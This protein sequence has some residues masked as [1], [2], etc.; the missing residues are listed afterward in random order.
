MIK[1]KIQNTSNS[2]LKSI[3]SCMEILERTLTLCHQKGATD[4][5]VDFQQ[6]HGFGVDVRM[7][8]LESI[9]FH[10]KQGL[11]VVVYRGQ[12]KGAA[13]TTDLR[14][15][16]I[17]WAVQAACD[18]ASVSAEDP[19]YGL[20]DGSIWSTLM[21]NDLDLYHPWDIN[22]DQAIEKAL[23]LETHARQQ[24]ARIVNSDG[25]SVSSYQFVRAGMNSRGFRE[26]TYSTRHGMSCSLVA[27]QGEDMQSDYAWSS[28]RRFE[29]LDAIEI[30]GKRAADRVCQRLG[31]R[32]IPTQQ[33]PIIF[34]NR[35]SGGL[36]GSFISAITGTQLYRKNTFLYEA[37]G[38][39]IFP[40]FMHIQEYPHLKN[41][42]SSA[43]YDGDG[44]PTHDNVFIERGVL[45]QYALGVYSARRLQLQPTGNADGVHNLHVQSTV[46]DMQELIQGLDKAFLVTDLMGQ[47]VQILTGNYSRGASGFWIEN[48][49]IQYSV[50][51]VTIA[52]NLKDMFKGILAVGADVNKNYSTQCGSILIDKMTIAGR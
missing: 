4:A 43:N 16:S 26:C 42:Q 18:M 50:E 33:V 6:E 45:K 29:D 10:Q 25:A 41:G 20:A 8:E 39:S 19:Y 36:I 49:K 35:L 23:A 21:N 12:R 22:P 52:G 44:I 13:S 28:A 30:I 47:G 14:P 7:G 3:D 9:G 32:I 38:Q 27:K 46:K 37:L 15:S 1:T 2:P 51:G 11:D 40:E 31:G 17:E 5:V 48:G 24:D 34:S